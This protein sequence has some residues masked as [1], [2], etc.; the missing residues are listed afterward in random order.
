M[1]EEETDLAVPDGMSMPLSEAPI[2]AKTLM[3][4]QGTPTVPAR[5]Q[6]SP[7]GWQ[8]MLAA[9]LVGRAIGVSEMESIHSLY[10]VNGQVA[11]TG[12]LMSALIH[13]AGHQLRIEVKPKEVTA[14]GFRR[15][16]VTHE[17]TE[18]GSWTFGEVDAKR[19]GLDKKDTYK[20]YPHTMWM[21]RAV[22]N[23]C[24]VF[25]PDVI[26]GMG[27]YVPEEIGVE[28]AEV[29]RLPDEIEL[30]DA[31]DELGMDEAVVDVVDVL[32]AEVIG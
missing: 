16:Y 31:T 32:D 30:V 6:N 7:T 19:A 14:T 23:L 10:L 17:L 27:A 25:F 22:S 5:Y 28:G 20:S 13:R 9:V 26:S 21:W 4:L 24:R 3:M 29:D 1:A 8:D 12:K 2:T 11:M 15:D 18:V